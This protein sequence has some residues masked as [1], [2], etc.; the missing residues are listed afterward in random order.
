M[1][2]DTLL[3]RA[4]YVL[5]PADSIWIRPGYEGIAYTDGDATEQRLATILAD[6]TD[7]SVFSPELASQWTDW[8][9]MY[10]LSSSRA[11]LLRPFRDR[12]E[13]SDVLE[14]GAGCG[15][16]TRYL[17]ECGAR[18]LALE[19]SPRRAAMARSRT[20][21]LD[22]VTVMTDRF[23]QFVC[24]QRFDVVTLIGVLEYA[25][26]FT[27]GDEPALRMLMR[28]RDLLKPGGK[29]IVAI[30]NQLG[31]KYFAGAAED[32]LSVPMV[33][34]EGRYH[35]KGPRT[36]GR[37]TLAG[38]LHRAGLI[39]QQFLAPFPDYKLP[40]SIV[41]EQALSSETFDAAALAW[42]SARRD[43]QLPRYLAF[44]PEL[45]W[46]EVRANGLTL[47]LA[48][49]FL[50]VA[51]TTDKPFTDP[52]ILAYHYST[53]HRLP[54]YC[55]ETRFRQE[56]N[57]IEV[58]YSLLGQAAAAV[59]RL[60]RFCV[61]ERANYIIGSP[62]STELMTLVTHDG[63]R[64]EEVGTF[65]RRYLV[66]V[67]SL[68][69]STEEPFQVASLATLVPGEF[70]DAVPQNI[71]I[72]PDG[73]GHLIDHEWTL[74]NPFPVGWLLYRALL[75]LIMSLTRL[76]R[77][78]SGFTATRAGFMMAAFE[79]AG[80][81]VDKELLLHYG[82]LEIQVQAEIEGEEEPDYTRWGPK[83]P[84]PGRVL[85]H[86]VAADRD[87]QVAQLIQEAA[88]VAKE[89]AFEIRRRNR[90]I[91]FW[92]RELRKTEHKISVNRRNQARNPVIRIA[93]ALSRLNFRK[94]LEFRRLRQAL[95][96]HPLLDRAWYLR[97]YPDVSGRQLDPVRHF[98]F[99]GAEDER[100]P[101]PFFNT[102]WYLETYQ[103]V[104]LA[105]MNP[106]LHYLLHGQEEGTDPNPYFD[107]RWYRETY[108][109]ATA[110]DLHPL[111]HYIRHGRLGTT[112]PNPYFDTN[113][114]RRTYSDIVDNDLDPLLHY[115]LHGIDEERNPSPHFDACWYLETYPDVATSGQ[116]PLLHFL[117][118]GELQGLN[119]NRFFDSHWYRQH[120]GEEDGGDMR[121]L[122][123]FLMIGMREGN[124]PHP[125]LRLED[126][127]R[128]I[129]SVE[130]QPG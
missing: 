127:L 99:F 44:A 116:D 7:L 16:M 5:S 33:G 64:M 15:A 70:F 97:E 66:I 122:R 94:W 1:Y 65:L 68:V 124:S 104:A 55:K 51:G 79:A 43:Y 80:F 75:L 88:R 113:W 34:I 41:T 118:Q 29:L 61:P 3:A 6:A 93:L 90:K 22:N 121:P 81:P 69:N 37:A 77:S 71:L 76:H 45:A 85:L 109:Q 8:A 54:A 129:Q 73:H 57:R 130:G 78:N 106:L 52:S 4:G 59:N 50:V 17:G 32:H 12:L 117:Q 107:T 26:L 83:E 42:Q 28:V 126:Y 36:F 2:F 39:S 62:L 24:E 123:H 108:P 105:G 110:E 98:V 63:W 125:D 11:N 10:H 9:S 128:R 53:S 111:L 82:R 21:D 20:R 38:L 120:Y 18:V 58:Q 74:T 89:H 46:P 103:E 60:V 27:D 114:Y 102:E 67:E 119:P 96:D 56:D 101:N 84:L 49:S 14:I 112:N 23:D 13:Q 47:D 48:N 30:E 86:E 115:I 91:S 100:N 31:L 92:C 87:Q 25:A 72:D 95:Q 40:V 35:E 19:G